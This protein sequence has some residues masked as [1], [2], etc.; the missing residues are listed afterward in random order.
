KI[1]RLVAIIGGYVLIR[2]LFMTHLKNKQLRDRIA[3]DKKMQV[4][5]LID[6]PDLIEAAQ[7]TANEPLEFGWGKKTRRNIKIQKE[8][9]EKTL[10]DLASRVDLDDD[11][12]KDIAELLEN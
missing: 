1:V 2:S 6:R 12:D 10:D 11:E 4:E 9:F 8:I 3:D 5:G 7:A